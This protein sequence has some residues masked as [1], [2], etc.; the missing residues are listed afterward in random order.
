[1]KRT[2]SFFFLLVSLVY[3]GIVAEING[4]K[5]TTEEF[6]K[7]FY[8]FWERIAHLPFSRPTR[9]DKKVFL[10]EYVRDLIILKEAEKEGIFVSKRE[11]EEFIRNRI[12]IRKKNF[13]SSLINLIKAEI[14]TEKLLR[15]LV[16]DKEVEEIPENK[17]RAYY[18]FY[19]REFRFPTSYKLIAVSAENLEIAKRA[20]KLMEKGII[21]KKMVGIEL[22]KPLWYSRSAFPGILRRKFV[23][24]RKGAVSEPIRLNGKFYVFKILD[25]RPAGII[26]FEKAKGLIKLKILEEKRKEAFKEWLRER[27]QN[28][29]IKFYWENL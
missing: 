4:R 10:I 19:K 3:G 9:E 5:I 12:D 24:L 22:S 21:P 25:V 20:K 29:R 16:D 18:E 8:T 26:P 23:S 27:V 11:L 28:Y 15:K 14:V 2:F 6:N 7:V 17:L 1:M 13:S